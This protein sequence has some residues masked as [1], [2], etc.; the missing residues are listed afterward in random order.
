MLQNTSFEEDEVISFGASRNMFHIY[1]AIHK[2]THKNCVQ[3][4]NQ[5]FRKH[6]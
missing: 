5:E 4:R 2:L 3:K 6:L 1:D